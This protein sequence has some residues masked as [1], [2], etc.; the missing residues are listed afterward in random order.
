MATVK[1]PVCGMGIDQAAAAASREARGRTY[2]FCSEVCLKQLERDP[3]KY[4]A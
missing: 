4:T 2:Y 3:R 1:D